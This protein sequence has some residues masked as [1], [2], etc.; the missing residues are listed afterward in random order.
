MVPFSPAAQTA[1]AAVVAVHRQHRRFLAHVGRSECDL[2]K[3]RAYPAK[4]SSQALRISAF[5]RARGDGH[6]HVVHFLVLPERLSLGAG[7]FSVCSKLL[8]SN[9][10]QGMK[11]ASAVPLYKTSITFKVA[12]SCVAP[13]R[14]LAAQ[15][16]RGVAESWYRDRLRC[17]S[18]AQHLLANSGLN[19]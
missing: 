16:V 17:S 7:G 5:H 10:R 3:R 8:F 2:C 11:R 14:P 18:H 12:R 9:G 15:R 6:Y 1:L 19:P 4:R 13:T